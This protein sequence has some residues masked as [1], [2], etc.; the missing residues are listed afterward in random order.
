MVYA[1]IGEGLNILDEAVEAETRQQQRGSEVWV[2]P[3]ESADMAKLQEKKQ[4]VVRKLATPTPPKST[5]EKET[6]ELEPVEDARIDQAIASI[7]ARLQ[8][9]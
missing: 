2:E 6:L 1:L 7:S 4:Q 5:L 3:S 8:Q 9:W